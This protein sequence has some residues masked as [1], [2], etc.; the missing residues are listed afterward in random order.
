MT[1]KELMERLK[2]ISKEGGEDAEVLIKDEEFGFEQDIKYVFLDKY[3]NSVHL[4]ILYD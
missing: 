4:G 1:V 2:T 3:S